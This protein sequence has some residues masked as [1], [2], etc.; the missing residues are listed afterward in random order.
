MWERPFRRGIGLVEGVLIA[1]LVAVLVIGVLIVYG[2][3]SPSCN[4]PTPTC[5][6][7]ACAEGPMPC[8]QIQQDL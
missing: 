3:T 5:G 1:A 8:G 2:Q 6:N 7:S 4:T